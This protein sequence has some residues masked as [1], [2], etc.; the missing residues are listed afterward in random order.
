MSELHCISHKPIAISLLIYVSFR[1][2]EFLVFRFFP[3][4]RCREGEAWKSRG[5]LAIAILL[6]RLKRTFA[7]MKIPRTGK[8]GKVPLHKRQ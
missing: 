3:L 2:R 4:P 7:E 6:K 8:S 5:A 1:K